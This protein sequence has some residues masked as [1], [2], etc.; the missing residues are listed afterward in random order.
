MSI[1]FILDLSKDFCHCVTVQQLLCTPP[2]VTEMI[3]VPVLYL[4]VLGGGNSLNMLENIASFPVLYLAAVSHGF[5]MRR[6]P[7][8]SL[9]ALT[10][11]VMYVPFI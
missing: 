6:K 3:S 10:V 1:L 8:N 4:I 2:R 7:A 11:S 9:R 5:R